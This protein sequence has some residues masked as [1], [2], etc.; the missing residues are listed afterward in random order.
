MP[1][2]LAPGVFV[3]ETSFRH[4]SIE[5]VGT[6]VAGLCGPT[7]YGPLRGKPEVV[8]SFAE[9][10]RIFGDSRDLDFGGAVTN[11]TALAARAFFDNGGKQ[12]YVS[13]VVNGVND[14]SAEEAGTATRASKASANSVVKFQA[15]FAGKYGNFTL[16]LRFRDAQSLVAFDGKSNVENNE[17][18]ILTATDV[19][20]EAVGGTPTASIFPV[21]ITALVKAQTITEG[22]DQIQVLAIQGAH[23]TITASDGSPVE[24]DD[25]GDK[26]LRIDQLP[27]GFRLVSASLVDPSSGP[28]DEGET[29]LIRLRET[30][31]DGL[32]SVVGDL[33]TRKTLFG[34]FNKQAGTITFAK[35]KNE[36][37]NDVTLPV[38]ALAAL[39]DQ[40]IAV[41]V[42]REF[43]VDVRNGATGEVIKTY[44]VCS[45]SPSGPTSLPARLPETPSKRYDYL[46]SPVSC[47][48]QSGSNKAAIL[49][50]L[51]SLCDESALTQPEHGE[52]PRF[53]IELQGG[54]DGEAPVAADY[55]GESDEVLGSTGL[56]AFED[57][58]DI[59]M[60]LTPH[61]A[62]LDDTAHTGV[63]TE[64]QKHCRKMR[65]RIGIVDS[66]AGMAIS[67][68]R[69]FAS[70]FDDSRLALYYPWVITS[71]PNGVLPE[72]ATPPSGFIAGVFAF[73]DVG[74]GV[75]KAPA[76]E[77]VLGALRFETPINS[78]QQELLN[79]EGIN[80]LRAL[81]GRGFRIWGA[82]TL[83]SD[84]EWKYVNVRRYFL[85]LERSIERS[86]QWVV[87]EP[88][89]EHLW[90]NVRQTVES[91]L[92]N[93]WRNGRL[94]G[95]SPKEAYF[96]RCDRTTMT[97]NDLDEGR[98]VCLVGVAPLRPA[99]FV[100]FRI[101]QKT[102]DA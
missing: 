79:P 5:G 28:L 91:F 85:Y 101:G 20:K 29:V 12:L 30:V 86:T 54:S 48:I 74:R 73:T 96:V 58:E 93:E 72:V 15:R 3:E 32:K 11:H 57:I 98:L 84:P 18:L 27:T 68:V 35:G 55:A 99:E 31:P 4:K 37:G 65:Y 39:K 61:A 13:R 94:L 70:K 52:D 63:V 10:E 90:D 87:F 80:C 60:V 1:E 53:L 42:L 89:G 16:E 47:S 66:R 49:D 97:Q 56:V 76:N 92:F 46:T 67:E 75:H 51:I 22:E 102:A 78:F 19:P 9:F 21:S 8:T 71:D 25:F 38:T 26:Q 81:P 41:S 100:I 83:S 64:V 82:R 6:S 59:A 33:G 7:R 14:G 44:G 45:P 17:T 88:N 23:A 77:V 69:A 95:S 24:L 62:T 50:A 2:Y 34:V 36:L 40:L 43:D